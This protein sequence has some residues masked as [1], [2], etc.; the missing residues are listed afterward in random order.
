MQPW[1]EFDYF[2]RLFFF[3]DFV[4]RWPVVEDA[5][6]LLSVLA[7]VAGMH[8]GIGRHVGVVFAGVGGCVV[9]RSRAGRGRGDP[10][11]GGARCGSVVRLR[12]RRA[13]RVQ[14]AK[15]NP[16]ATSRDARRS[17]R[18]RCHRQCLSLH[19]DR[20]VAALV[21]MDC[22]AGRM[23]ERKDA[24]APRFHRY[25]IQV[26]TSSNHTPLRRIGMLERNTL[27][28]TKSALRNRFG[29]DERSKIIVCGA[30]RTC[31]VVAKQLP[32]R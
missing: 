25:L 29:F 3:A 17:M 21:V 22:L 30:W 28:G 11:E 15:A 14:A 27:A 24:M 19:V 12:S 16:R 23:V 13:I 6:V 18:R 10:A 9:L 4:V 20:L 31:L 7:T 32:C 26:G 8:D 1:R 2:R 5:G